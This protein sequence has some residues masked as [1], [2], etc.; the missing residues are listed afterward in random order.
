M[1]DKQSEINNDQDNSNKLLN[2]DTTIN[3][4]LSNNNN[5]PYI[6]INNNENEN[7]LS[8]LDDDDPMHV[9][10][11]E[12]Q[13]LSCWPSLYKL[14]FTCCGRKI[15]YFGWCS[16]TGAT[17]FAAFLGIAIG[18]AIALSPPQTTM[19]DTIE[20]IQKN[21]TESN[22]GNMT[23]ENI[24]NTKI[25]NGEFVIY[26][27]IENET[28]IEV[29]YTHLTPYAKAIVEFP[30]TIPLY[31]LTSTCAAIQGTIWAW[32]IQPGNLGK[33][34]TDFIGSKS[35][36]DNDILITD[37]LFAVL[38]NAVP[39]NIVTAM[40]DLMIL[41]VIVFFLC[42]GIILQHNTVPKIERNTVLNASHA[43]L[44]CCMKAIV[45]IVWFTPIGMLSLICLKIAGTADLIHLLSALGFYIMCVAIG[46]LIHTFGFYAILFWLTTRLNPYTFY[47]KICAAPLLAFATSSS[48][49][50][51]PRSLM[52]A[53][54]AGI[55]KEV[56]SFIIPLG[57]AI[58]M[59]GTA[60][61]FP[62]MVGLIA[63]LNGVTLD[64]GQIIV[65]LI[66]SVIISIGTAPIPNV[67]MVYLTMLFE[68]AGIGQYAGEGI[69]TLFVLDWLVD[70]IETA[71]NVTSD[72]YVA[73]ISDVI[74]A[75]NSKIGKDNCCG[76][77]CV[78]DSKKKG[79]YQ[80]PND[81]VEQQTEMTIN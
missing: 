12:E 9:D 51:L 41:G 38:Y 32:V 70:R 4:N 81:Q 13:W 68:S 57:A 40:S 65:V 30:I 31:L 7:E 56:Y 58:N 46:H 15:H 49:A 48:A 66:L 61:G 69:A 26:Y 27:S 11:N 71:V 72:Q 73:K 64:I 33:A 59:D 5:D 28:Q 67:G 14:H 18:L 24:T 22:I 60:L 20:Y 47:Y 17:M 44:R 77:C 62:I 21:I 43:I 76:W 36:G 23:I 3:N 29:P 2:G 10:F 54:E 25:I 80:Q 19:V 63:Q 42:L 52:V 6:P 16:L 39:P 50:T 37:A 34:D 35:T 53:E 8:Y 74:D 79:E 45:W 78:G 55:R 1:S 75:R